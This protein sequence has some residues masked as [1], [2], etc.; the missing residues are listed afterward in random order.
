M[1]RISASQ[2]ALGVLAAALLANTAHA[3]STASQLE[4]IIVTGAKTASSVGGLLVEQTRPKTRSTVSQEYINTQV[5]GQTIIQT[6]NL[7]PGLNFTNS[8]PY[9][10]SGGNLRMRGFDGP[11]ISLTI[12]GIP[13]NDTGNYAIYTN[14]QMDAEVIDQ[15][16]VNLGTTDVDSPTASATGGT[17]NYTTR[18]PTLDP[19]MLVQGSI[20][21][22]DYK[23]VIGIA[24][25]GELFAGG[26]R[27]WLSG[28]VQDYDKFKGPGDLNKKQVNAKLYWPIGDAGDFFSI[29]A[30]YNRNRNVFYSD[31]TLAQFKAD[32]SGESSEFTSTYTPVTAVNGS[33]DTSASTNTTYYK[34]RINPSNT[35]NIRGQARI[36]LTD[37]LLFTFDP[38]YQY[39]LAN[40]GGSQNFNENDARL[41]GS[42]TAAGVDLN[43]DTDT[44]D[45]IQLYRPNTTNTH[46]FG[47]TTSLVWDIND[48]QRVRIAYTWDR[49]RHRQT[50]QAGYIMA[51]G[52]PEN[53]FAG[54]N[55]RAVETADGN[56]LRTRDRKSIALLNQFSGEYSGRFMEDKLRVNLGLRAPFFKRELNQYCYTIRT[57]SSAQGSLN[58]NQYCTSGAVPSSATG[59][60]APYSETKKYDKLLP[61]VGLSFAVTPDATVYASYAKGFSAPRTDNLYGSSKL[62]EAA[63]GEGAQPETTDSIDVG[64]RFNNGVFRTQVAGWFTKYDNR[65]ISAFDQDS[66]LNID[67]NVGRVDLYG[68][69][70]EAGMQPTENFNLY[71]SGAYT[72]SEVKDDLQ[73]GF[74]TTTNTATFAATGGKELV[75]TPK[76][77]VAARAQYTIALFDIGLQVKHVGPR[78]STDVNDQRAPAYTVADFDLTA[79]IGQTFGLEG[80]YL[81]LNVTNLF[82]AEYLGNISSRTNATGTGASQPTYSIGAPRTVQGSL[83]V[84]F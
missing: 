53:V 73:T 3:Q 69:E 81:R 21:S 54:R 9:G 23:R 59:V 84:V 50:G 25:S 80:T 5:S 12:D 17:I 46:R 26:P 63:G 56:E 51:D 20:G 42:S 48:D 67:R 82:D 65:I 40:G 34:L 45:S 27:L 29:A 79:N 70:V 22:F 13:L 2:A 62:A 64:F 55:G 19:Q 35:G 60:I 28:S 16:N 8:D 43:G 24:D 44:R 38:S 75:E 52:S 7:I 15:A 37:G 68:L 33:T 76:F 77:T 74:N 58:S 32:S 47:L 36:G 78:W 61:N 30:H 41:R 11:R 66:G 18:I 72:H 1:I 57:L 14:Q 6:L 49:G 10:S 71:V 31:P 39:V 4:E 83:R